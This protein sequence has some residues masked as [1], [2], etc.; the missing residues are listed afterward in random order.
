M[1]NTDPTKN[2]AWTQVLVKG[3]QFLLLIRHLSCYSYIQWSSVSLVMERG[4]KNIYV[5]SKRF[6]LIWNRDFSQRS[7]RSWWRPYNFCRD[8][9]NLG[10]RVLVWIAFVSAAE[11][12]PENH[13]LYKNVWVMK[14]KLHTLVMMAYC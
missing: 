2:R 3:K 12:C 13:K 1:S 5:K 14:C 4:K 10:E 6:I 9:F 11:L 7:T 8:D